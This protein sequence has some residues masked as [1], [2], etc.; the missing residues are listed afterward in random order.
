MWIYHVLTPHYN[1][2]TPWAGS[3]AIGTT[4][5]RQPQMLAP[6][7]PHPPCPHP[8]AIPPA[9]RSVEAARWAVSPP[10]RTSLSYVCVIVTLF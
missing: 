3:S 2:P 6:P 10:I 7:P 8:G 1:S 5:S 9:P 4:R